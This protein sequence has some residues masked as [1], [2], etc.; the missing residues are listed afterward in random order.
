MEAEEE[1]RESVSETV[2]NGE[3]AEG[4][5]AFET[6]WNEPAAIP[7][8]TACM[9]ERESGGGGYSRGEVVK[10]KWGKGRWRLRIG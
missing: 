7:S 1:E 2:A 10:N 5:G 4:P 9:F 8:L 3:S 6:G